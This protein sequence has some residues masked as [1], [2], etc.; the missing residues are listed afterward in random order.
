MLSFLLT[1]RQFGRAVRY[2]GQ[3]PAFQ[4]LA[5]VANRGSLQSYRE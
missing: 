1:I 5:L 3:D 2:A 4:F